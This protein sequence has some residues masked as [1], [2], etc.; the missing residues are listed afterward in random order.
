MA[1]LSTSEK[2]QIT[3]AIYHLLILHQNGLRE[4]EI[5]EIIQLERRRLNNYLRELK[6]ADK[7]YKEGWEWFAY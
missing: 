2:E 6:D 7:I 4:R 1:R 5:S 3:A